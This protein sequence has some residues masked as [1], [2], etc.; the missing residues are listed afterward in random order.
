MSIKNVAA[1]AIS[2]VGVHWKFIGW[3]YFGVGGM[4]SR[5]FLNLLSLVLDGK[6]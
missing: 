4:V 2:Q 1:T 5:V 6:L 3:S